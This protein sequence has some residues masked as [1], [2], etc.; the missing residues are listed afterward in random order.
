[1]SLDNMPVCKRR[2]QYCRFHKKDMSFYGRCGHPNFTSKK[3]Y[4][5]NSGYPISSTIESWVASMG[6]SRFSKAM[7]SK[8]I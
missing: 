4:P 2:C 7:K 1:M 6:C 3:L 8:A 5:F